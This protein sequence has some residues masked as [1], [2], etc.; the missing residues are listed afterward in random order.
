METSDGGEARATL[1]NASRNVLTVISTTKRKE[2]T[3]DDSTALFLDTI[4]IAIFARDFLNIS[5]STY[6]AGFNKY[7]FARYSVAGV[8]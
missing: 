1:T 2:V 3:W 5:H 4:G 8:R 6:V 7:H